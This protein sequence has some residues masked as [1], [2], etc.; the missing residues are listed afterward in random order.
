MITEPAF[1]PDS[2][3]SNTD[4]AD[5]IATTPDVTPTDTAVVSP[6]SET[7]STSD[8]ITG[9]IS[10]DDLESI[11]ENLLAQQN[12]ELK[13]IEETEKTPTEESISLEEYNRDMT[14]IEDFIAEKEASV[15]EI[16]SQIE[17][18]TTTIQEYDSVWNRAI[19]HELGDVI[20]A[21]ILGEE[22][23][24]PAHMKS[25]NWSRLE[26]NVHLYPLVQR[27]L[28]GEDVSIPNYLKEILDS[29]KEML[30]IQK[31]IAATPPAPPPEKKNVMSNV[32]KIKNTL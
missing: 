13:T 30:G 27:V 22:E 12:D 28:Q 10:T 17:T 29:R 11:I 6:E 23:S 32:L 7:L 2:T 3:S 26:K 1:F 14:I 31:N 20:K 24:I 8:D 9:W 16:N 15:S 25:E 18:L 21:V 4:G 19:E 5:V